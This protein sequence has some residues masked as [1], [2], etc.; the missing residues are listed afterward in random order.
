MKKNRWLLLL[1][2]LVITVSSCG[3]GNAVAMEQVLGELVQEGTYSEQSF[4]LE[5]IPAYQGDA[6][7]VLNQNVPDFTE[8]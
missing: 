2:S 3:C 4:D 5:S 8:D 1:L 7:V 6:Y